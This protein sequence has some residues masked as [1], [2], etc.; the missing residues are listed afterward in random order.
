M[1]GDQLGGYDGKAPSIQRI[2]SWHA[3]MARESLGSAFELD[4]KMAIMLLMDAIHVGDKTV[5]H[6]HE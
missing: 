3:Y 5:V 1:R 2:L 6:A 4:G